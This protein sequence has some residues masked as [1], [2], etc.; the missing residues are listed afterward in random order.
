[1]IYKPDYLC[2]LH[3]HTSRSDGND[4][5]QQLVENASDIGMKVIAITD[6]DVIPEE[7]IEVNGIFVSTI[8]YARTFNLEVLL[9]IEFSCDSDVD[10][11]HIIGLG[12]NWD[13]ERFVTEEENLKLSKIEGYKKLVSK[14]TEHG[15]EVSWEE[16]LEN[17]DGFRTPQEIQRK[18]IFELIASKG[19][20]KT[21]QEAKLMVRDNAELNVKREKI[22]PL[23]AIELIKSTGGISILAHPFL[24]DE[25]INQQGIR[26]KREDYIRVL[27]ES[28]LDGIEASYTYHKTSY[29]GNLKDYEVEQRIF[30][31]YSDKVKIISG[32]SDYHNDFKK[33]VRNSRM[34]GEKGI[35]WE[36]FIKNKYLY[37]LIAYGRK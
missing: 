12:C 16:L 17:N 5:Y 6:H 36:Y 37:A 19:Y 10:D 15:I 25:V 34:I 7:K 9:G 31:T 29:K 2:D 32:G 24:I 14:L 8:D 33:G 4:T 26:I 20:T 30:D 13:D 28:G 18:H 21:W 11:V 23:K 22:H 3:C 35:T 1:M 27:I